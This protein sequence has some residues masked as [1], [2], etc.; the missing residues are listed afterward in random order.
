MAFDELNE[1]RHVGGFEEGV[2]VREGL[3]EGW[4]VVY[5]TAHY[6]DGGFRAL[7]LVGLEG[8]EAAQRL[9]LSALADYAGIQNDDVGVLS[10]PCGDVAQLLQLIGQPPRV[11]D[12]HLTT[13]SP[14]MIVFHQQLSYRFTPRERKAGCTIVS[15]LS[16][17]HARPY[18][19]M[20]STRSKSW[21]KEAMA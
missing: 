1:S 5:Q 2:H 19:S 18:N 8:A 16:P 12:V 6:S 11:S 4:D 17:N 21:S 14:N 3:S 13:N 20:K 7:F 9:V 15:K 10:P